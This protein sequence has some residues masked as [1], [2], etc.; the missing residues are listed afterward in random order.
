MELWGGPIVL[1]QIENE[2]GPMEYELGA[3]GK[4]YTQWAAHMAVRDEVKNMMKRDLK[5]SVESDFFFKCDIC[6][7]ITKVQTFSPMKRS[8]HVID[9]TEGKTNR[10]FLLWMDG[11]ELNHKKLN[12]GGT[13]STSIEIR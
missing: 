6:L 7:T 3:P 4:T 10:Y 9:D 11:L 12:Q 5:C 2:Y 8:L 1:S 13:T